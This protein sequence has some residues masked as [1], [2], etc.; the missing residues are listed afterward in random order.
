MYIYINIP[1]GYV[2]TSSSLHS[3]CPNSTDSPW[4]HVVPPPLSL[5]RGNLTPPQGA[6]SPHQYSQFALG[7]RRLFYKSTKSII[8]LN[9]NLK[10]TGYRL[11]AFVNIFKCKRFNSKTQIKN[12]MISNRFFVFIRKYVAH[13]APN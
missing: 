7:K 3:N 11:T 9:S 4:S 6:L 10:D 5:L 12:K 1:A 13:C 8:L 2:V